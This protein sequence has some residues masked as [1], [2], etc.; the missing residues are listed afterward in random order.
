MEPVS[1]GARLMFLWGVLQPKKVLA[2]Q[3]GPR[4]AS[5]WLSLRSPYGGGAA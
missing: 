2:T 4:R 3:K 5:A 1:S